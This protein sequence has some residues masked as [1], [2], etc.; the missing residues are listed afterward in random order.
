MQNEEAK[1]FLLGMGNVLIKYGKQY[2]A[3]F[4]DGQ[5]RNDIPRS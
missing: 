5:R 3:V 4:V 1:I 2:S